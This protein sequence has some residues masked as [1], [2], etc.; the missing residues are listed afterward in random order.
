MSPENIKSIASKL[1]RSLVLYDIESS[2]LD[3][4]KDQPVSFAAIK[5]W[6]DAKSKEVYLEFK[7][8]VLINPRA[9]EIN[10]FTA[11]KL[12]DAKPFSFYAKELALL[13]K[14]SDVAG[15]NIE[16]FDIPML[17]N[18][19]IANGIK[20][21]FKEA[22][23]ADCYKIYCSHQKRKLADSYK[24]YTGKEIEL[25]HHALG[26]VKS[27]IEILDKQLSIEASSV[28]NMVEKYNAVK[29]GNTIEHI[30]IIDGNHVINFG[31]KYKGVLVKEC[32]KSFLRW[33]E[34][35][36]FPDKVK[37]IIKS[38]L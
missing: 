35:K 20:N 29:D 16:R 1:T 8:T 15:Y 17:D 21:V 25:A 30:I 13:F 9:A 23:V 26:D 28:D 10:G 14:D 38:Y 22:K 34:T 31:T 37:E 2:G 11:E 24:Y 12:K 5:I 33:I 36:T 3:V 4:K 27:T 7:P 32:P 6:P 18:M 19:F